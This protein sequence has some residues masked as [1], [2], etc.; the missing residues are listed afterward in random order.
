MVTAIRTS[1][2]AARSAKHGSRQ[3]PNDN[4]GERLASH[5][6]LGVETRQIGAIE[7]Q[8]PKNLAAPKQRNDKL[9]AGRGI[10][11]DMAGE[12]LHI[13]H[14]DRAALPRGGATDAGAG[15][16]VDARGPSLKRAQYQ[17][18][19][20]QQVKPGPIKSRQR[21]VDRGGGVGGI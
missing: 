7:I 17:H 2:D 6:I 3:M 14:Q 19:V 20:T 5:L 4:G 1:W 18:T 10:A 13:R 9:G 15:F 21:M 12:L 11:G 8:H 16:Y